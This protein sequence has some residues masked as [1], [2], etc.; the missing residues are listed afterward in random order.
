MLRFCHAHYASCSLCS[1]QFIFRIPELKDSLHLFLFL[2]KNNIIFTKPSTHAL[3]LNLNHQHTLFR[4]NRQKYLH[5][6]LQMVIHFAG[7]EIKIFEASHNLQSQP[8]IFLPFFPPKHEVIS[9]KKG[10]INYGRRDLLESVWPFG[11]CTHRKTTCEKLFAV[12]LRIRPLSGQYLGTTSF[13]VTQ[14]SPDGQWL[15]SNT[16]LKGWPVAV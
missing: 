10:R 4:W 9:E 14:P 2:G 8:R 16:Q 5:F 7:A 1:Q 12:S 11:Y 6:A 13:A 15:Y 3:Q